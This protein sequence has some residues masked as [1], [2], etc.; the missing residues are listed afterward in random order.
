MSFFPIHCGREMAFAVGVFH[1]KNFTCLDDTDFAITGS[2]L[3]G[4]VEVNYILTA[5]G[6]VPIQVIIAGGATKNYPGSRHC[7]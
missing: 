5:W 1:K 3:H 7:F 2:D 6:R 4:R